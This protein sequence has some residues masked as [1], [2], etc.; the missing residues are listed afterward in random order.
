MTASSASRPSSAKATAQPSFIMRPGVP[1][2]DW[3]VVT[4]PVVKDAVLA[5]FESEHILN[6]W[7][8]YSPAE[9]RVR[10]AL[11]GLYAEQGRAPTI[12]VLAARARL[13]TAEARGQLA[14]LRQRDLVVLSRDGERIIGAY[15]FTDRDTGQ[16]V[17]LD[18]RTANAMCAV[19]AL[20][21]GAMLR[22]DIQ[23][24]SRCHRS[25]TAIRITTRD[26]GRAIAVARPETT[27][28]WLSLRYEG[29]SAAHSLCTVTVFFATDDHLEAWHKDQPADMRGVRLSLAEALE[30]GRAIFGPSLAGIDARTGSAQRLDALSVGG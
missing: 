19:D 24:D 5:M 20:G 28:V 3:S 4:S 14:E 10:A 1:C 15:P 27:V 23:I 8:G 29:G 9:D 25:G 17:K 12:D 7:S 22:R 6:R 11:L 30:A 21:V 16:R 26:R 18:G 13:D 2:P